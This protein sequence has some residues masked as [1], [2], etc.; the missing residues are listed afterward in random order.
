MDSFIF[1]FCSIFLKF[2]R[3]RIGDCGKEEGGWEGSWAVMGLETLDLLNF[4]DF[5]IF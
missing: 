3:T 1:D 2:W 4:S 5:F